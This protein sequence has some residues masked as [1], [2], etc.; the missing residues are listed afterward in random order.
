MR[1][2]TNSN[3][4]IYLLQDSA[5]ALSFSLKAD[6]R[7][8]YSVLEEKKG[9]ALLEDEDT[10]AAIDAVSNAAAYGEEAASRASLAARTTGMKKRALRHR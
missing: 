5:S 9:L 6:I 7:T 2:H 3:K 1:R 8:V 10:A 4:I